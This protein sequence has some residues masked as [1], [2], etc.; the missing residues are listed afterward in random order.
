MDAPKPIP[1]KPFSIFRNWGNEQKQW[2]FLGA[3]ISVLLLTIASIRTTKSVNYDPEYGVKKVVPILFDTEVVTIAPT[4]SPDSR[5]YTIIPGSTS[6]WKIRLTSRGGTTFTKNKK[7]YEE[8]SVLWLARYKRTIDS[9]SE[10]HEHSI[11]GFDAYRTVKVN[12]R[13]LN[14]KPRAKVYEEHRMVH[15][16]GERAF[17]LP[18]FSPEITIVNRPKGNL[19]VGFLML[20]NWWWEGDKPIAQTTSP[21]INEPIPDRLKSKMLKLLDDADRVDG[22]KR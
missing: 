5:S 4:K 6:E 2:F 10:I 19:T 17:V 13:N 12:E 22:L 20:Q 11:F 14:G 1:T 3:G 9:E 21:S 18:I 7:T 16:T 8:T 15:L